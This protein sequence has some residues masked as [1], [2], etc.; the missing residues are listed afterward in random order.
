MQK[1]HGGPRRGLALGASLALALSADVAQ[2]VDFPERLPSTASEAP[3]R[4]WSLADIVEVT[5]IVSTAIDSAGRTAAFVVEQPSL[6]D[7]TVRYALYAAALDGGGVHK[8][9]EAR[10][11]GDLQRQGDDGWTA[12]VDFGAGVQLYAI[13]ATGHARPLVVRPTVPFGGADGLA[14]SVSEARRD[15][16][17][18]AYGWN[19]AG[20]AFWYLTAVPVTPGG[21]A[22]ANAFGLVYDPSLA[23]AADFYS[24][25]RADA[26]ELHVVNARTGADLRVGSWPGRRGLVQQ[27]VQPG[28][29]AW[30]DDGRLTYTMPF[31]EPQGLVERTA[32]YDL[33]RDQSDIAPEGTPGRFA[34]PLAEGGLTPLRGP[35]G[36]WS[37]ARLDATGRRV[38]DLGP[39]DFGALGGPFGAWRDGHGHALFGAVY[40]DRFG[41]FAYPSYAAGRRLAA[42]PASLSHCSFDRRLSVGVCAR[43]TQ[44]EAPALVVV[45][46]SSGE[47]RPLATPNARYGAIRPLRVE[48]FTWTNRRGHPGW[49]YVAYPRDYRPGQRYPTLVISHAADARNAFADP[50]FQW[51]FPVQLFAE[52][53]YLVLSVN[54]RTIDTPAL[55][56]MAGVANTVSV[57]R[58]QDSA[59]LEAVANM[60]AAAKVWI[61][62]GVAD[63]DRLGIAGYSR[64]GIVTTLTLSQ[65]TLFRAGISADTGFYNAS[66]YWRGDQV[67]KLY[68]RLYGGSPFDPKA[69][70]AY[71]A[72]SPSLRADHFSGPLMQLFTGD[73]APAGLELDTALRVAGVP[74]ELVAYVGETHG[75]HR[76]VSQLSAMT[77]SLDWFDFWLRDA[78]DPSPEKSDQS[79]RWR[80]AALRWGGARPV[81]PEGPAKAKDVTH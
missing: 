13:D 27:I 17:V 14:L 75:F 42:D 69:I 38:E 18:I 29:V 19:D 28:R 53:G 31:L 56:A 71:R 45:Q 26:I 66:G 72:L 52:R 39:V 80:D 33:A 40:R 79:R 74:T 32:T 65:S 2:A 15:T 30:A 7:D 6:A 48:T 60:E 22:D 3:S 58:M 1:R 78:A 46:P 10:F 37:L 43:E 63:Q 47:T 64:G 49:G 50:A 41:L 11:I 5:R 54:E 55:E 62:R 25:V 12:R 34:A 21:D 77:R 81:P 59:A 35:E 70:A 57:R 23:I 44:T 24:D 9:F 73:V 36:A 76:P 4:P 16:G 20:S 8:L 67:R 61:D 68:D 51:A